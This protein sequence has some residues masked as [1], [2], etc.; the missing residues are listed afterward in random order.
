MLGELLVGV[1]GGQLGL[2]VLAL[3]DLG[4]FRQG[5]GVHQ[6]PALHAVVALGDGELRAGRRPLAS[7]TPQRRLGQAGCQVQQREGVDADALGH[8]AGGAAVAQ[9]QGQHAL[10]LTRLEDHRQARACARH[11]PGSTRS[12]S[13]RPRA[14]ASATDTDSGLPQVA[15]VM[16]SG[17]SWSQP[18]LA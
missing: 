4:E 15:L 16:G 17:S 12:P 11:A 5:E 1:E 2:V 9:G 18:L 6:V 10:G 13:W 14:F 7:F 3:G 8:A